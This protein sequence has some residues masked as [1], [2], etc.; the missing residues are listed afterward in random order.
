[1][2]GK[3]YSVQVNQA[4]YTSQLTAFLQEQ[5]VLSGQVPLVHVWHHNVQTLETS[6][7]STV[8]R[9][10]DTWDKALSSSPPSP[11]TQIQGAHNPPCLPRSAS[12]SG[13]CP[14]HNE[15]L[16]ALPHPPGW[17]VPIGSSSV[18]HLGQSTRL[19]PSPTL[20]KHWT[21]VIILSR[22]LL[23]YNRSACYHRQL[24]NQTELV[25]FGMGQSL[26]VGR[27]GGQDNF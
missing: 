25:Q 4:M 22:F 10:S 26:Y 23:Y 8:T 21:Q 17:A 13:S 20:L 3:Y 2:L 18:Q 14:S 6:W 12:R 1:M 15:P 19:P 7:S 9:K 16:V 24:S 27:W 11:F 5:N